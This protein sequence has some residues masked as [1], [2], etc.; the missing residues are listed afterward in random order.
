M[1]CCPNERARLPHI[2]I[3]HSPLPLDMDALNA[4]L[5]AAAMGMDALPTGGLR[6][7]NH[8]VTIARTGDGREDAGFIYVTVRLGKGRDEATRGAIGETLMAELTDFASDHFSSH[9]LSLGLEV[10]EIAGRTWKHNNIH[11]ILK[12][13]T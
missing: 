3:E 5:H 9:P 2:I 10:E 8:P 4:R 13:S 11:S 6:V 7:R 1:T 12:A